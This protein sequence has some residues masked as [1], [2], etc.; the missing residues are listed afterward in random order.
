MHRSRPEPAVGQVARVPTTGTS[1]GGPDEAGLT[2]RMLP[3]GIVYITW[4]EFA[5]TG[6][7]KI[8]DEVRKMMDKGLAAGAQ[9]VDLRPARQ[10][11]WLRRRHDRERSSST[12]SRC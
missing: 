12:G 5:V 7:Y 4:R 11:R 2:G 10:R 9:G 8:F 3:G 1:L 6:T